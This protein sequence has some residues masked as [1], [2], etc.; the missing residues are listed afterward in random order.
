MLLGKAQKLAE[1]GHAGQFRKGGKIPYVEHCEIVV[2]YLIA[3]GIQD[4]LILA[5]AYVHDLLEDTT[6]TE[7]D[8]ASE[9][10]ETVLKKVM[11]LTKTAAMTKEEYLDRV[12]KEGDI[13]VVLIKAVDRIC[14]TKDF[15]RDGK[16]DYAKK[17]FAKAGSVF[18]RLERDKEDLGVIYFRLL[19]LKSS[20]EKLIE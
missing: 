3:L 20:V 4:E 15:V 14:N 11:A 18:E 5:T 13:F 17:Y 6:I 2:S 19:S 1:A 9:L 12:S 8:I 10:G 16:R 7:S